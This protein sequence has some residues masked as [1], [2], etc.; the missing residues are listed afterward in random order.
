MLSLSK[1]FETTWAEEVVMDGVSTEQASVEFGGLRWQ[2][3]WRQDW[4]DGHPLILYELSRCH[5]NTPDWVEH[6][7]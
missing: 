3:H 1:I 5:G 6:P 4:Y 2:M 7:H